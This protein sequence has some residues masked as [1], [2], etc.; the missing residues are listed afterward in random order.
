MVLD[1][2]EL[3]AQTL[4]ENLLTLEQ[5]APALKKQMQQ[6][7]MQNGAKNVVDVI[8]AVWDGTHG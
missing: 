7:N 3:T 4:L 2:K 6:S 5:Q 8:C 1:Q